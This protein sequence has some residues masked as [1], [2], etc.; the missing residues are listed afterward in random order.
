MKA[1]GRLG[2]ALILIAGGN[3]GAAE[4]GT[5]F[6]AER[7]SD[8]RVLRSHRA[9]QSVNP[10]SVIKVA[11]SLAALRGLGPDFR[12]TTE[13][14]CRGTCTVTEGVLDGDLVILGGGDPDFQ[15]EN[16]WVAARVLTDRGIGRV[17]GDLVIRGVF[18]LGWEHGVERRRTDP[19]ARAREMGTRLRDALDVARWNRTLHAS[20]EDAAPRHGWPIESEPS[21]R[22]AGAVRLD[23]A[24]EPP[25]ITLVRH[26]SNPLRMTLKRFN[27]FSN[28]D[29]VRV[30]D[31]VGGPPGIE[32]MLRDTVGDLPGA[33]RVSTGS[34]ERTNRLT[35][36]QMV[37]LLWAFDATC[38]EFGLEPADILPIPGCAP[39]SLPRMFPALSGGVGAKKVVVKSGTLTS[40]D[41]GVAVLAGLFTT[42][43]GETVAF[44]VGSERAGSHLKRS[45]LEQQRW[46]LDLIGLAGGAATRPCGPPLPFSDS[47]AVAVS[48]GN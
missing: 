15:A 31:H 47:E 18:Y 17:R 42:P 1:A 40:T 34:G 16:A 37:A 14:G 32:A 43:E 33:I 20:W 35:A 39:G 26:E 6:H 45:R 11:T 36:R 44:C 24:P 4:D 5:V 22:I 38:R 8:R 13:V 29:I 3:L 41:G 28:N 48:I 7:A 19:E 21:I 10:A 23:R 9:D 27:T 25:R 30:A 2:L 46:V 12:F